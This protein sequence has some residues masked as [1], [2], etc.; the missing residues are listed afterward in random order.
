MENS[1]LVELAIEALEARRREIEQE[2][3]RLKGGVKGE[4][5]AARKGNISRS[6]AVS[7]AMKAYWAR[8]KANKALAAPKAAKPGRGPRV[9]D[10]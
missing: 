1:R 9:Q 6:R 3:E 10:R 7:A 4:A 5:L 8:R 2:I